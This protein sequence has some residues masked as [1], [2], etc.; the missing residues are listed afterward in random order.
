MKKVITIEN[1]AKKVF[2]KS[3]L[4]Y[5]AEKNWSLFISSMVPTGCD[6]HVSWFKGTITVTTDKQKAALQKAFERRAKYLRSKMPNENMDAYWK[7]R[8][9]SHAEKLKAEKDEKEIEAMLEDDGIGSVKRAI[10]KQLNTGCHVGKFKARYS[11][12]N[13]IYCFE[14]KDW[15]GYSRSCGYPMII[16]SF[17]LYIRHGYHLFYIGGLLTFVKG[18]KIIR[19]GMACE[20]IEQ[21]KSI[22][23]IRTVKG[24]LVRGEHIEAKSLRTAKKI[25]AEHRAKQLSIILKDRKRKEKRDKA[26]SSLIITVEDSLASGNCLPGTQS[27]KYKYEKAIGHEATCITARDLRKYADKFGVSYYADRV[28]NYLMKK[29]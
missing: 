2:S 14:D 27:F 3:E 5:I 8:D 28:I 18:N 6:G 24:Y 21:G 26:E 1:Y 9:K 29:E 13:K 20:W 12:D 16:R 25:N 19:D 4:R 10:Y 7:E 23:D 15:N 11:K 17:T 22:A